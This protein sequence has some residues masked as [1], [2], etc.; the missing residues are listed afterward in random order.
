[1][2]VVRPLLLLT[3][4]AALA[5]LLPPQ[6]SRLPGFVMEVL[7]PEAGG[8]RLAMPP[9]VAAILLDAVAPPGPSYWAERLAAP[10]AGRPL[11]LL[12]TAG[13]PDPPFTDGLPKPL[14]VS[15]LLQV[16]QAR[17][18]SFDASPEAALP[19]G[20]FAFHP[21]GRALAVP[22]GQRMRLTEKEAA[23]L[24]RLHQAGGQVV[25]RQ[26]LLDD[27]WGYSATVATHTLE[28]H[29]YRLRRKMEAAPGGADLLRTD[30]GGYRLALAAPQKDPAA[31]RKEAAAPRG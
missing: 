30:E 25:T 23:I 29:V 2:P 24:L 11:L 9:Y 16:L 12:G 22:G 26:A 31:P 7:S 17:L 14:R 3:T 18:A 6:M 15:Q 4:D 1:M 28:T 20:P 10:L 5:A 27:V 13:P 19:L 8:T 21:A